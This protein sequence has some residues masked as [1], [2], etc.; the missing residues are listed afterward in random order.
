MGCHATAKWT[1]IPIQS[2]HP[3]NFPIALSG[4][5]ESEAVQVSDGAFLGRLSGRYLAERYCGLWW[6]SPW[7][8]SRNSVWRLG[9]GEDAGEEALFLLADAVGGAADEAVAGVG[10]GYVVEDVGEVGGSEGEEVA[11]R[12]QV[13][14]LGRGVEGDIEDDAGE[15]G[16]GFF[17]PKGFMVAGLG[18]DEHGSDEAGGVVGVGA[19]GVDEVEGVVGGLAAGDGEG[20]EGGDDLTEAFAAEA[21]GDGEGLALD[22]GAEDAT[23]ARAKAG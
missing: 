1:P 5:T 14:V 20:I 3:P 15:E 21:G 8:E 16:G 9:G 7:G 17:L 18:D 13:A 12:A 11:D 2:G 6:V 4:R 22:V 19:G 10:V 23:Q